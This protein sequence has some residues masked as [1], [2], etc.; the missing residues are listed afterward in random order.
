MT[1]VYLPTEYLNK[2]CYQIND[3]YIRVWNSINNNSYNTY[4]DVF[5]N[6]NYLVREG[7]TN[8]YN[9]VSCSTMYEF[10]DNVFYRNDIDKILVIFFILLLICFYFPYRIISRIFGRWLK[11]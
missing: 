3:G 6:N 5:T 2:P 9:N 4:Y 8:Y 11:F 10:T 7:Y 1:K